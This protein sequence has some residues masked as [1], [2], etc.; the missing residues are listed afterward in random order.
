MKSSDDEELWIINS[1]LIK[2]YEKRKYF[3][4]NDVKVN[5]QLNVRLG[6]IIPS[7]RCACNVLYDILLPPI[8]WKKKLNHPWEDDWFELYI[9][10]EL[11]R[12]LRSPS[13]FSKFLRNL[14]WSPST[15]IK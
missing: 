7:Q 10:V 4:S 12:N 11:D 8:P 9:I 5:A 13:A 6:A 1:S 2:S 14:S 3:I 15:R